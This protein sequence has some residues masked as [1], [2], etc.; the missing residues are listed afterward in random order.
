MYKSNSYLAE[1]YVVQ[2][3]TREGWGECRVNIRKDKPGVEEERDKNK[4][5]RTLVINGEIKDGI[6]DGKLGAPGK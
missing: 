1:G 6:G 2:R 5:I 4:V 3:Y